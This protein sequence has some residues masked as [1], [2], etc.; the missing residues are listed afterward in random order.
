[1]SV[2][3]CLAIVAVV[4]VCLEPVRWSR[5][6]QGLIGRVFMDVALLLSPAGC[7]GLLLPVEVSLL[8]SV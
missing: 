3:M 8:L 5:E 2:V 7:N 6:G 4:C 1:M